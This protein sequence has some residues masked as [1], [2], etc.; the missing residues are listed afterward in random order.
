MKLGEFE[1]KSSHIT[2]VVFAFLLVVIYTGISRE[3][4]SS[5]GTKYIFEENQRLESFCDSLGLNENIA[6]NQCIGVRD[7]KYVEINPYYYNG[8]WYIDGREER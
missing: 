3:Y 6:T 7:G 8:N 5:T 2:F 1:V 4:S